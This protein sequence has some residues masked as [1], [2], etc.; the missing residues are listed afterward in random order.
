MGKCLSKQVPEDGVVGEASAR[1]DIE[2]PNVHSLSSPT[3][4]PIICEST[5]GGTAGNASTTADATGEFESKLLISCD[6][7]SFKTIILGS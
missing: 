5:I 6:K 3:I 2:H 1:N 4:E 7:I